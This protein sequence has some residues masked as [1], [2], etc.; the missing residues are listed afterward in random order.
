MFELA[1]AFIEPI[2][3]AAR[4]PQPEIALRVSGNEIKTI[5]SVERVF[6]VGNVMGDLPG[7]SI[8]SVQGAGTEA[9]PHNA[10]GVLMQRNDPAGRET[11][12]V[13]AIMPVTAELF[14]LEIE[15]VKPPIRSAHPQQAGPVLIK[16]DDSV[17]AEAF[18]VILIALKAARETFF[19]PI[20]VIESQTRRHPESLLP[21]LQQLAGVIG[22]SARI[23]WIRSEPL[24]LTII[25]DQSENGSIHQ[26]P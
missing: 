22:D 2:Q 26:H 12:G 16:G 13:G 18:R 1:R 8:Q 17:T 14:L 7:L 5:T 19:L 20:E 24:R 15:D 11:I 10:V 25:F 4:A 21:I 23:Q 3:T 6:V 9:R